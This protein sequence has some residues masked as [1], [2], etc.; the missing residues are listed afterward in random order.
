MSFIVMW[1]PKHCKH[2]TLPTNGLCGLPIRVP[3]GRT[4]LIKPR[5]RM[6]GM[7]N[8]SEL[9]AN[10]MA[11]RKKVIIPEKPQFR[12]RDCAHSYDWHSKAIDGRDICADANLMQRPN[13][14]NGA[15]FS[16]TRN[17]NISNAGTMSK[18]NLCDNCKHWTR[19]FDG[20]YCCVCAK[21]HPG[22]D[23]YWRCRYYQ[24]KK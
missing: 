4:T 7:V 8:L 2:D 9:N 19:A 3:S 11:A 5:S 20:F 15:S 22:N 14:A 16:T 13:T 18:T 12:C 1:Q 6:S 17:V 23:G 21:C 10:D 24:P